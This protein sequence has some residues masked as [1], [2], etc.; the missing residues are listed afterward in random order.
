MSTTS[1]GFLMPEIEEEFGID[2]KV[3]VEVTISQEKISKKLPEIAPS[4]LNIEKDGTLK[5]VF[6]FAATIRVE[7]NESDWIDVRSMYTTFQLRNRLKVN[8]TTDEETGEQRFNIDGDIKGLELAM[9]KIFKHDAN[10]TETDS[11]SAVDKEEFDD[12]E[13][14]EEDDGQDNRAFTE[15]S[16]LEAMLVQS[17]INHKLD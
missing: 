4:G 15:G 14:S 12:D 10:G 1:L 8:T 11:E 2:K 7:R 3:D 13:D 5:I 9:L 17:L 16:K 6:N